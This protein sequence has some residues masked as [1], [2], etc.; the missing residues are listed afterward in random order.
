MMVSGSDEAEL[1]CVLE[2]R[3]LD[4]LF[5]R[6]IYG[7]P[8]SKDEIFEREKQAGHLDSNSIYRR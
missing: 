5:D 1:R 6:G 8:A 3:G 2:A 7:S 4:K